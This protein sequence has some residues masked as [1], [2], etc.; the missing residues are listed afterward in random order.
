MAQT[1]EVQEAVNEYLSNLRLRVKYKSLAKKT[2]TLYEQRLNVFASYCQDRS[3]TLDLVRNK[4]VEAFLEMLQATHKSHKKGCDIS[5]QTLAGYVRIIHT[6]LQWCLDDEEFEKFVTEIGIKRIKMPKL[7]EFV[8]TTFTASHI[9]QLMCACEKEAFPILQLRD[10]TILAV[11]LDTGV[12]AEEMCT[13]TM[14]HVHLDPNDA[15]IKVVG[16]RKKW[17]EIPLGEKSRRLLKQYIRAREDKEKKQ[18]IAHEEVVFVGRYQGE[19]LTPSG[20]LQLVRRLARWAG[21]EEELRCS[22]HTFRHTFARAFWLQTHDL[23]ALS[24]Y[25]R[26]ADVKTTMEYLKT[27]T[28]TDVRKTAQFYSIFDEM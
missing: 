9:E 6:F 16:K 27:L 12:R 24:K 14:E 2:Y 23:L 10:K 3:I 17:R 11:L 25:L 15:Y 21:I 26:H 19:Q 18:K 8:I 4:N 28:S 7:P 20:L 1:A 5:P 22:P 13:L